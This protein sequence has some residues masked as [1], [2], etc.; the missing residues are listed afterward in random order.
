MN[1]WM[2]ESMVPIMSK[3][4]ICENFALGFYLKGHCPDDCAFDEIVEALQQDDGS[5]D[6]D[7]QI[8]P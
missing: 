5:G 8:L 4:T 6:L 3:L 2:I 1:Y 7:F